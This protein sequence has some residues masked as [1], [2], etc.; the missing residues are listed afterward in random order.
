MMPPLVL[1]GSFVKAS[2]DLDR[3]SER[4]GRSV[5]GIDK[6]LEQARQY[7]KGLERQRSIDGRD[8]GMSR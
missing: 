3:A 6:D 7:V 4:L 1:Y 5:Q 2:R 8:D